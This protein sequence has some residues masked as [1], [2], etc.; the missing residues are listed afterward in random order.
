MHHSYVVNI[1]HITKILKKD[2]YSC[3]FINGIALPVAKR[4]Q[5]EFIKFIKL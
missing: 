4:R 5:E 2:G 1:K 3:E